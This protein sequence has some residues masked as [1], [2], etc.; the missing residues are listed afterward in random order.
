MVYKMSSGVNGDINTANTCECE[1]GLPFP[2]SLGTI[3]VI[4]QHKT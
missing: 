3:F 1:S 2:A 4:I